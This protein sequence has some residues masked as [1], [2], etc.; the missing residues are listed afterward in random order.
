MLGYTCLQSDLNPVVTKISLKLY[1]IAALAADGLETPVLVV[2]N[3]SC[4]TSAGLQPIITAK[5]ELASEPP[6]HD[7]NHSVALSLIYA[8]HHAQVKLHVLSPGI[9]IFP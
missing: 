2:Y 5:T 3:V 4:E 1:A 8:P 9:T 7:L 6:A